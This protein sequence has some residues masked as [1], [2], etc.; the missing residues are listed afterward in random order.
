MIKLKCAFARE[1]RFAL[2]MLDAHHML[3]R[4]L[5]A[6]ACVVILVPCHLFSEVIRVWLMGARLP[7]RI[8]EVKSF[9]VFVCVSAFGS[10]E[11]F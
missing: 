11:E 4:K 3:A 8:S 7:S 2:I 10:S 9:N 1:T 5:I 6:T